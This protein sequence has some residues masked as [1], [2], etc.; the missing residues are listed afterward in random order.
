M[1]VTTKIAKTCYITAKGLIC[2]APAA[3]ICW[4]SL[5]HCFKDISTENLPSLACQTFALYCGTP[6]TIVAIGGSICDPDTMRRVKG[7]AKFGINL[8]TGPAY[9]ADSCLAGVETVLF[10]KSL[11]ILSN[12]PFLLN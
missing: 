4:K 12:G 2:Q 1:G 6:L 3:Q 8:F 9:I 11:P 5:T 10:G 7:V